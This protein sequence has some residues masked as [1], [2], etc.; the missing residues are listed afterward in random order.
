[1]GGGVRKRWRVREGEGELT[2]PEAESD[3]QFGWSGFGIACESRRA[4]APR[5]AANESAA[6]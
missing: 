2:V 5:A 4:L 3:S 1:L 6:K